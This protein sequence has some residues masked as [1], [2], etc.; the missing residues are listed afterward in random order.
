MKT[1]K[2][3]TNQKYSVSRLAAVQAI[4]MMEF[5]AAPVDDLI[6][7]F[8]K[9]IIGGTALIDNPDGNFEET[10]TLTKMDLKLF[11]RLARGV[12]FHFEELSQT[13]FKNISG[14]WRKEKIP[15][16]VKAI[17]I[18]GAYELFHEPNTPKQIII[19]EYVDLASAFYNSPEVALVNAILDKIAQEARVT[20]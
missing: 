10:V 16:L 2:K 7:F 19:D 3:I 9:G 6:G 14:S 1:K 17:I 13:V 11:G 18:C 15:K 5:E 4:Y 8:E 20:L 12:A